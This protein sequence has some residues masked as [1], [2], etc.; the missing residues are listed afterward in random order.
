M[1]VHENF[2]SLYLHTIQILSISGKLTT[3][4]QHF[5]DNHPEHCQGDVNKEMIIPDIFRQD[6][7]LQ[8]VT[9]GSYYFL[10]HLLVSQAKNQIFMVV[11]MFN[12]SNQ[13]E[14]W[15][16]ELHVYNK[17]QARR[18]FFYTDSCKSIGDNVNEIFT[19]YDCAVLPLAYSVAMAK[20]RAL[21]YKFYIRQTDQH[22]NNYPKKNVPQQFSGPRKQFHK[23]NRN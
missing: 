17:A 22:F 6:R 18:K 3:L 9:L 13:A 1:P 16:Y 23:F 19:N 12:T 10:V 8:L 2:W 20:S 5:Q 14:K 21:T 4:K 7:F 11:Q 15:I